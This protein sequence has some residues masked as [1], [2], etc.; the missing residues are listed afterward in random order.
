M[1]KPSYFIEYL[2]A[3]CLISI[4]FG[5]FGAAFHLLREH[6]YLLSLV[7]GVG[8]GAAVA[9]KKDLRIEELL[10]Y[11]IGLIGMSLII[12]IMIGG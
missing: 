4:S 12:Q 8:I 2:L 7:L 1:S 5:L 11:I 10:P 6:I 9:W 3:G